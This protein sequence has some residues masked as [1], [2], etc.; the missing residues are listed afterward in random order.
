MP[1]SPFKEPYYPI[2]KIKTGL[3]TPGNEFVEYLRFDQDYI[4]LYHELPNGE[5][6]TGSI[7]FSGG[8]RLALKRFDASDDVK[9][10]NQINSR[11]QSN[12]ISPTPVQIS[13]TDA[14][15]ARGFI[16][17]YFVQRRDD[18]IQTIIEI[19]ADQFAL[20]NSKNRRG[21]SALIW[22]S[23]IIEWQLIKGRYAGDINL[24]AVNSIK[25]KFPGIEKYLV[26]NLEFTI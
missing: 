24:N 9:K 1:L 2:S 26:D 6:W 19:N 12:Y 3:Y 8:V 25:T 21:I 13:P 15:Y 17:R 4:G 22:N 20:I 11:A 23:T 5:W 10:Y 14:D 16:E 7:P 18:P